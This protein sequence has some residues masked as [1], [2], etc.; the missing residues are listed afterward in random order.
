MRLSSSTVTCLGR[1]PARGRG[2]LLRRRHPMLSAIGAVRRC[3]L[4]VVDAHER[5][6][7][8]RPRTGRHSYHLGLPPTDVP[9]A[10]CCSPRSAQPP[11][12]QWPGAEGPSSPGRRPRRRNTRV[13]TRPG[14]PSRSR[15]ATAATSRRWPQTTGWVSYPVSSCIWTPA[16]RRCAM[17]SCLIPP[18]TPDHV[19]DQRFLASS[20]CSSL[21]CPWSR[22]VGFKTHL[23]HTSPLMRGPERLLLAVRSRT[24]CSIASA[25]WPGSSCSQILAAS[26]PDASAGRV[27][28]TSGDASD[29]RLPPG[30]GLGRQLQQVHVADINPLQSDAAVA[31]A[32]TSPRAWSIASAPAALRPAHHGAATRTSR[33]RC[34]KVAAPSS[35]PGGRMLVV[36]G[37]E[38]ELTYRPRTRAPPARRP[39]ATPPYR[40]WP[41]LCWP[42][43]GSPALGA[44]ARRLPGPH[45]GGRARVRDDRGPDSPQAAAGPVPQEHGDAGRPGGK[46]VRQRDRKANNR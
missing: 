17:F 18:R 16:L 28:V 27:A 5:P 23:T 19:S 43:A 2:L 13:A 33:A 7:G 22:G 45:H 32:G 14:S 30:V 38:V 26:Q 37:Q 34:R 4:V 42:W 9:A 3:R 21:A 44:G 6:A 10:P 24:S 1:D 11:H 20:A 39:I 41:A 25:A 31:I 8:R 36:E 40:R 29:L 35:A 15:S 12:L 46:P